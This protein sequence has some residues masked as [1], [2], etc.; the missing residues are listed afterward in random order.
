MNIAALAMKYRPVVLTLV[1]M[2]VAYGVF[3]FQTMPRREDPEFTIRSCV[4]STS[5]PGTPASKI[6]ELVTEPLERAIARI[7]EVS[8]IKSTTINGLSTINVDGE[9]SINKATIDNVW[10]KVRSEVELVRMPSQSVRPVVN[11]NFG[12]TSILVMGIYQVPLPGE[13]E[14]HPEHQYTPRQLEVYA[15]QVR[16]AI[17]LLDGV[18]SVDK[19]GVRNEAIYVETEIGNWSQIGLTTNEL[20]GLV[21]QRNTIASGGSIETAQGSYNVKP[22]G[23]LNAVKEIE[24]ITIAT[25]GGQDASGKAI[26]VRQVRLGDLGLTVE[27]SYVDPPDIMS[28]FTDERGSFP[29]VMLGVTM[30]SGQN[31]IDVC[32]RCTDRI[33]RLVN[34]EQTLPADLE[35]RPISNQAINVSGKIND[36]VSNVISAIVI[37]V[38]VVFLFVGLRTSLVMAANIP[39]VVLG[40]IAIINQLGIQLEQISLASIIIALGLL[41]DNAVQVCDQTRSNILDGMTPNDAAVEG[42][43]TLALPMLTGTLTTVAVFIPMLIA[44][45][46]SSK[47]YVYSLPVTL[48]VTLLLSWFLAMT[49]CVILAAA[50]IRAP[51]NPDRPSAP[52]PW[53]GYM[54]GK[55]WQSIKRMLKKKGRATEVATNV[56]QSGDSDNFILKIYGITVGIAVKFKW[57]T[58]AST[59]ALLVGSMQLPFGQEF[60]PQDRRDQ[61]FVNVILPE[62]ATINQTSETVARI[63]SMIKELSPQVDESG[64]TIERVR[65]MRCMIGRGGSRWALTVDPPSP[66]S[67][68]A[69]ILIQTNDAKQTRTLLRDIRRVSAQGDAKL[70]LQP[71]A[72]AR[73]IPKELSLGPPAPAIEL[74]VSGDGFADIGTLR[75]IAERVK[76]VLHND[77]GTWDVAD[78]WGVDGFQIELDIDD[79]KANLAG[80]TNQNVADTLS[81][82][83]SGLELSSFRENDHVVPVYFRLN[84]EQRQN[85][86][87]LDAAYVEGSN[88][89]LPLNS[90]ATIRQVFQ[91]VKIGRRNSNRTIKVTAEVREGFSGNDVVD[92]VLNSEAMHAIQSDLPAGYSVVVGGAKE[93]SVKAGTN[94]VMSFGISFLLIIIILVT[95]Y[96]GWSKTLVIMM[97]LPMALM[98]AFF[99]L[100]VTDSLFG[101]MPQLGLLSLFGIVLNTGIIFIEFADILI[102]RK[103][104]EVSGDGPINGLN[105]QQFRECLV[106]AGKMR[107]LPIFLTTAT[108]VGGLIPLAL[109]GGPLWEGM[110]WLMI[111][112]LLVA[113]LLTLYVV[114]ALYAILVETFRVKPLA[115]AT[116]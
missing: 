8:K 60:F 75:A 99:G 29:C 57:V 93:E 43:G 35:I 47:E 19:Y 42:A 109:S 104:E 89:K 1:A 63:E 39:I 61:F 116:N 78:S 28:R 84:P 113:T 37:V 53:L 33:D 23:D 41:V 73:I 27:R 21:D 56:E 85:L 13:S 52:L 4:V 17:R 10:D 46:G 49:V 88:G 65:N 108:T 105:K 90:I 70:G 30:K 97:T 87:A 68:V 69:E 24:S 32:N 54:G 95:Q 5:W 112:G 51:K 36:V 20:R 12:D 72:G 14:V 100:W 79:E 76:K 81:A 15:D 77:A 107:M 50:F 103:A 9:D 83:F 64:T 80:V 38:I 102:A 82:Y 25:G 16:A 110:S 31:I 66:G 59:I 115:D 26:P 101:F 48:S 94:M 91:P 45:Q 18:A 62:T 71:I 6:E 34:F 22:S 106:K 92:R 3:T 58:V 40:S 2:L 86:A 7:S 96:N 44:L 11:S 98:G 111:F 114:P 67:N 74:R 55:L